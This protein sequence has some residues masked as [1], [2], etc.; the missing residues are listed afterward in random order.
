[1]VLMRYAGIAGT[2]KSRIYMD[3]YNVESSKS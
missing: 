2:G 3:T 1:M